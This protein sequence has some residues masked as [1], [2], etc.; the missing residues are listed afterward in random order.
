MILDD[1]VLATRKR[2][3]IKKREIPLEKIKAQAIALA[4]REREFTYPFEQAISRSDI[5]FIC[6]VKRA[7]PSKG[8]IA[9]EFPYLAIAREYERAGADCISVLTE[10]EYFKG[11]DCYL[12]EI[13]QIVGIPILRKDFI[14]DEYMIYEAKLMG[15]SCILLIAALLDTKTIKDFIKICD[16]LGMS[17][18]VEIHN[19]KEIT[20]AIESRARLIG[21]NNRNLRDFTVDI[22]NSVRMRNKIPRDILMIAESGI[23]TA[24]DI[25][26]LRK[27]GVNGVLIGETLMRSQDKTAMLAELRG[28]V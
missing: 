24:D 14:I 5:S 18:L 20:S 7:S 13:N 16:S 2:V 3:E 4:E 26:M 15:A 9:E 22:Q 21:V 10:P 8:V 6:E 1:I 11:N 12:K 17:A 19:E 25:Q 27:H 23:K 28:V